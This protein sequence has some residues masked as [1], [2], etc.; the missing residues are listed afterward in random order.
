MYDLVRSWNSERGFVFNPHVMRFVTPERDFE[1]I[2]NEMITP[3]GK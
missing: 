3:Y 1:I 2:S